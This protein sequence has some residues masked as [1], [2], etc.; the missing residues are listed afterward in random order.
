MC[1]ERHFKQTSLLLGQMKPGR[2]ENWLGKYL[3]R[4]MGIFAGVLLK[5]MK[6]LVSPYEGPEL[7][8]K[9]LLLVDSM[10]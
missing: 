6:S 8:G 3:V 7:L 2:G 4:R 10:N 1:K 5:H 9:L